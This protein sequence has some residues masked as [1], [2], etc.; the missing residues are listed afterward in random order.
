VELSIGSLQ[1]PGTSRRELAARCES[2]LR[3]RPDGGLTG[4]QR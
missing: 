3:A 1:L 2:A 4:R